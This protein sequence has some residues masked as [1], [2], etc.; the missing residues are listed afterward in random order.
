LQKEDKERVVAELTE[1]L[2]RSETL[3]VADYRGLTMPQIDAL[4]GRLI[5]QGAT[6]TVVKNTLT[7]R[8]AEAAGADTL[9]ALLEGPSAIAFIEADGDP[10]AVAKALADSARE[11]QVLA[12][13]GGVMSGRAITGEDVDALAKLPPI[14]VLRGQVI[15]AVIAPLQALIGLVNAPLQNL[16]G[17]LDARIEQLSEQGEAAPTEPVAEATTTTEEETQEAE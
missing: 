2:R 3:I 11:T 1:K 14:E 4:R 12:I 5:E 8:A 16:Y 9:L 17:L 7:R 10:V 13:R 6:F 15:G